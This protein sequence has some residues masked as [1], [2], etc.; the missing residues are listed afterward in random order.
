MSYSRWSTS[1]VVNKQFW[2]D[3]SV[4]DQNETSKRIQLPHDPTTNPG[5][6]SNV[7]WSHHINPDTDIRKCTKKSCPLRHKWLHQ[8]NTR[9]RDKHVNITWVWEC[10]NW[11]SP[12][13]TYVDLWFCCH[14]VWG[15]SLA[16]W[17]RH[18]VQRR[19]ARFLINDY[20]SRTQGCV[21]S[22]LTSLEWQTIEQRRRISRLI[23]MYKI[24]H[25]LVDIDPARL[26]PQTWWQQN[27]RST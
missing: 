11:T 3:Q 4:V 14:Q 25:Q 13:R 22:M 2:S 10:H 6:R 23:M 27:Q 19:A 26:I 5:I 17:Y 8:Q 1:L 7:L 20:I 12:G 15:I 9:M 24:Q 18:Y 21:T 16:G